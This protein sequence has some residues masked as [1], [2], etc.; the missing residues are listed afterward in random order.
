M[1]HT[2]KQFLLIAAQPC[3]FVYIDRAGLGERA[4]KKGGRQRKREGKGREGA[5]TAEPGTTI[6]SP[7]ATNL[8]GCQIKQDA[9][10][11]FKFIALCP[12]KGERQR[13]RRR[14][15]RSQIS[16]VYPG[17]GLLACLAESCQLLLLLETT[18]LR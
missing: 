3:D 9:S 15:R 10:N 2:T 16:R 18:L 17:V 6:C 5:Y 11:Y 8:F 7:W 13:R 12:A 14:Q 4:M 1:K